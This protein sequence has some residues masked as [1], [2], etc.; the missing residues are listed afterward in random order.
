MVNDLEKRTTLEDKS[1]LYQFGKRT[2]WISL[3]FAIIKLKNVQKWDR[4]KKKP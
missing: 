1:D 4:S 2:L 3:L